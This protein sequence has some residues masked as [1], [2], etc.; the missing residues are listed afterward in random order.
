[1]SD[2]GRIREQAARGERAKQ[3]VSQDIVQEAFAAIEKTIIDGW[4]NSAADEGVARENAYI[5]L[6]L[7]QNFR[8]Q[9]TV[10]IATGEAAKKE[11][12]SINDPSRIRRLI[13]GRR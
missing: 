2:E 3:I 9:F 1:M 12:L 10:A 5:M 7:Y 8:Q 6:R 11:L 4:K 13:S